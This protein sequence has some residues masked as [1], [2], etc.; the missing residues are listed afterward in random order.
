MREGEVSAVEGSDRDGVC[1][2]VIAEERLRPLSRDEL[3]RYHRNALVPQVGLVG[4]QRIRASRIL[5]IGAGGLGAPAALYLA[6]AGVGTIGLIDDDDVDVS[7][8]Q[9]QVIHAT[10]AVGRPKVDSAAEAIR[11]L[12]PDV[13]VVAHRTRLTADNA[14]DLLGGWD[15][16]IDGTDNFPTRYLVN[17]AAVM[18]GLPLVH[19][20]VLGF[21][22][23]VGVFDARRGPCYRCLHP[24]PPPAGSVPSCAEAGV[25]GVLPGIIGTMQAAEALKLVIGGGQPLLGRLAML[26]AWGA[27]LR[28]IPVAK[29]PACP[30]CGEDP[31]ITTLVTE[32]GACALPR[33][34]ETDAQPQEPGGDSRQ[35]PESSESGSA[36]AS[37]IQ[38]GGEVLGSSGAGVDAVSA[39]ELRRLLEGDVPPALLDVREDIEVALE[40]MEDALH[41]PLREV[42]ARMDELDGD[43]P[44]VVVCAAGVRS[45]RAIEALRAA[46]YSG[47]LLSLEGGMRAWVSGRP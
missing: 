41:I 14:R 19:G 17:D 11:A 15:V 27:H 47:R 4:Q 13:E 30:V 40:P 18:L 34:P 16:V 21:N 29:N 33:T 37:R 10:A 8:L 38:E 9:R 1:G 28:E 23:Q 31:S 3:E 7:N 5:L 39:T 20:A 6:A 25:L 22:G 42:V 24:A 26:D 45:V 43:R 46:G 44:T 35:Q 2:S 36:A 32:A 12:N